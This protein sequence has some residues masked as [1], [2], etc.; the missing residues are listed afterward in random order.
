MSYGRG[1]I[2]VVVVKL[3]MIIN[4]VMRDSVAV[5]SSRQTI[6]ITIS[7]V[8][9]ILDRA[10][11]CGFRWQ[12]PTVFFFS[13]VMILLS[14]VVVSRLWECF[15]GLSLCSFSLQ[16]VLL[17]PNLAAPQVDAPVDAIMRQEVCQLL[18]VFCRPLMRS[19]KPL[20]HSMNILPSFA[21]YS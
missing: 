19:V 1:Q 15:I 16:H 9:T 10:G 20:P 11:G 8:I 5:V 4:V 7:L 6:A 18:F 3:S 21:L 13:F 12:F 2:V 17:D 14:G